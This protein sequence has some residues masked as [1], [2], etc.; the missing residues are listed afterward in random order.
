[1][2]FGIQGLLIRWNLLKTID[3]QNFEYAEN[4]EFEVHVRYSTFET[5]NRP[6]REVGLS[7]TLGVHLLR[8]W[9]RHLQ[10]Q[11]CLV[12]AIR[13]NV[14]M[15]RVLNVNLFGLRRA[16]LCFVCRSIGSR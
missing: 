12:Q 6:R 10:S 5:G 11:A 14:P 16:T 13:L 8:P 9:G 1:V 4:A 3:S 7:F 2:G 15:R